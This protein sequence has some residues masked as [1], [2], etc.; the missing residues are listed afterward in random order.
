MWCPLSEVIKLFL[1]RCGMAA[2]KVAE[3]VAKRG[4]LNVALQA[5][6]S[7]LSRA[8]H[9]QGSHERR[10]DG[11]WKLNGSMMK[12]ALILYVKAGYR[13]CVAVPFLA[14]EARKRNWC[15]KQDEDVAEIVEAEFL[16]ADVS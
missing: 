2:D 13:V 1:A 12:T 4:G 5:V 7:E 11:M 6:G 15:P 14:M 9:K 10:A 8:V 3:L 16:R